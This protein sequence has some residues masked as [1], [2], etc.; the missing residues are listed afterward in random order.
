MSIHFCIEQ[1]FFTEHLKQAQHVYENCT[2]N[3]NKTN[4]S[5]FFKT[6]CLTFRISTADK[7]G[8]TLGVTSGRLKYKLYIFH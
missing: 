8:V 2:L 7:N 1:S 6:C 4:P 3:E 5:L